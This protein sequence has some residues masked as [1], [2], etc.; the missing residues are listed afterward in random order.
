MVCFILLFLFDNIIHSLLLLIVVFISLHI[1]HS[2]NIYSNHH[3]ITYLIMILIFR[4][5]RLY[6]I[7]LSLIH[8]SIQHRHHHITHSLSNHSSIY[9][10]RRLH[11]IS[12]IYSFI[13]H[14]FSSSFIQPSFYVSIHRRST[15]S[16]NHNVT[17]T[18]SISSNHQTI[19]NKY[20]SSPLLSSCQTITLS[21]HHFSALYPIYLSST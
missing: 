15:Y 17:T 11:I 14:H 1:F 10:Q 21:H 3:V 12:S 6:I 4:Q 13:D 19:S 9:R 16:S 5:R 7:Y 20:S 2:S 18:Q 8:S